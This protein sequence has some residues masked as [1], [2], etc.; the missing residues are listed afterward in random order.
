LPVNP[1]P[2]PLPY[3]LPLSPAPPLTFFCLILL[4]ANR[5]PGHHPT[6]AHLQSPSCF[7][8]GQIRRRRSNARV[9]RRLLRLIYISIAI[10]DH[11]S[12]AGANHLASSPANLAGNLGELSSD[13][14]RP[15][16]LHRTP[17]IKSVIEP[18]RDNLVRPDLIRSNAPRWR[19]KRIGIGQ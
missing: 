12:I 14:L 2:P 4:A 10:A 5:A 6:R 3:L 11:R 7:A 17:Q 13:S 16:D 8:S 19:S 15:S 9:H 1:A 18:V